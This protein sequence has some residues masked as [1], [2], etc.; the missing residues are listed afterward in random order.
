VVILWPEQQPG[1]WNRPAVLSI[2][3]LAQDF[4]PTIEATAFLGAVVV[5]G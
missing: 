3:L 4:N 2:P 5:L 1:G